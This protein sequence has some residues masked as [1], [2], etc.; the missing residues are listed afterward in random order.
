[1]KGII[2]AGGSGTRLYP[3]T[4]VVSSYFA[5]IRQTNDILHSVLMLAGNSEII[6]ISTPA[7]LPRFRKLFGDGLQLGL[8]LDF[9]EQV[10]QIA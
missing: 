5:G 9:A 6:I 8:S 3:I 2:L 1:M 10:L 7:D 4:R